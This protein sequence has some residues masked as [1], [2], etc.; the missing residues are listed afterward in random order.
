MSCRGDVDFGRCCDGRCRGGLR[1]GVREGRPV[2]SAVRGRVDQLKVE[3]T[4]ASPWSCI[5]TPMYEPSCIL[6][7]SHA[8][9]PVFVPKEDI[10]CSGEETHWHLC[11]SCAIPRVHPLC[12]PIGLSFFIIGH[13]H[14]APG[15]CVTDGRLVLPRPISRNNTAL[16]ESA[17]SIPRDYDAS[18][19]D[20]NDVCI[21][22]R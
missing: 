14:P 13:T 16:I 6:I 4:R 12:S 11:L 2:W 20:R 21:G 5:W 18:E 9:R 17:Y 10:D 7:P 1:R 15:T 19:R 22:P 3:T 8:A